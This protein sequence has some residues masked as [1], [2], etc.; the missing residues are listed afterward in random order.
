MKTFS[1]NLG[2]SMVINI[3]LALFLRMF[4]H[5]FWHSVIMLVLPLPFSCPRPIFGSSN[6]WFS[7]IQNFSSLKLMWVLMTRCISFQCCERK[8]SSGGWQ[9]PSGS[10]VQPQHALQ[11]ECPAY[12]DLTPACKPV[13]KNTQRLHAVTPG[14]KTKVGVSWWIFILVIFPSLLN[15]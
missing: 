10:C 4:Q 15:H 2:E 14:G 11:V 3:S 12:P 5:T 8:D 6:S 9:G 13:G 1:F 7:R